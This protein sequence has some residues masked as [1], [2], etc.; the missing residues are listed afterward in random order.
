MK[1]A[2]LIRAM[3]CIR[4]THI[5]IMPLPACSRQW[6]RVSRRARLLA[7]TGRRP[8]RAAY[9]EKNGPAR[10]V[11]K[12]GEVETP[13]PGPGEVRVRLATSGVNPSDVKS[14]AGLTRKIAFP[15]VIPHSDGAGTID[16]V[17]DGVPAARGGEQVWA[18]NGT[19][20]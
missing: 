9:Y 19:V 20:G 3:W 14:R 11:L 1:A 16:H 10:D 6:S 2:V 17:G 7:T 15:R 13:R 18:W 5:R 4:P 12:V 8:M